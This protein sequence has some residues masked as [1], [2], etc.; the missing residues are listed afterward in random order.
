MA[1]TYPLTFPSG[2]PIEKMNTQPLSAVGK[3]V[4]AFSFASQTQDYR[5]QMW[6]HTVTTGILEPDE[7]DALEAFVLALNGVEGTFLFSDP[8][9]V[10]PRGVATGTP[11]VDGASQTGLTLNTKGWTINVT[12]ILKAGDQIQLGTGAN[13]RLHKVLVDVDSDGTG[14]AAIDLWPRLRESPADSATIITNDCHGI[15]KQANNKPRF[16]KKHPV[17]MDMTFNLVEA[18]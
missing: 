9:K 6:T 14:L 2:I 11:L 13:T 17:L 7:A 12:G 4:S 3:S 16:N 15:Y 10:T 18:L 1:I 8:S 5:G